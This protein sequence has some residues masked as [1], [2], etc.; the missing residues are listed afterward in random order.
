M[1]I[2]PSFLIGQPVIP[3]RQAGFNTVRLLVP[4]AELSC[5]HARLLARWAREFGTGTLMLTTRQNIQ[6]PFVPD[7]SVAPL[8][9]QLRTG[10]FRMERVARERMTSLTPEVRTQGLR[11][12]YQL[13]NGV[14]RGED[15]V[16]FI[17]TGGL[18]GL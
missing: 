15:A 4:R 2:A 10:F 18:P 17:M 11:G 7:A 9:A 16:L 3:Q 5:Q 13:R 12:L 1:D 8:Q 6:F 14:W